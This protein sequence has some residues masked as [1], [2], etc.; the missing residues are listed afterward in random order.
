MVYTIIDNEVIRNK[1]LRFTTKIVL[2]VILSYYNKEKGY[3]YPSQKTLMED[4]CIKDKN[5][6]IKAINELEE[7]GYIRRSV[8]KGT[9]NRYFIT[10][11]KNPTS[12][13]NTTSM[14][15]PTTVVGKTQLHQYEKPD[16]IITNTNTNTNTKKSVKKNIDKYKDLI[17]TYTDN[18]DLVKAINDFIDM[19]KKIKK[20]M[21][22]NALNLMLKKLDRLGNNDLEKIEILENSIMN[23]WQGIFELENKKAP[24]GVGTEKNNK[25]NNSICKQI[26]KY[27]Q[28]VE[29]GGWGV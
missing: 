10:S 2:I 27:T 28:K 29:V 21:T 1:D 16:T 22:E 17:D 7:K 11:M 12:S 6:L 26:N 9:N 25:V 23:S 24:I 14:K 18:S 3:S 13:E 5:T 4:T 20:P 8:G 15:N 19:R